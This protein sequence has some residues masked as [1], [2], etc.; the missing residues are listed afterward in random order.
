LQA[1]YLKLA[2]QAMNLSLLGL[3]DWGTEMRKAFGFVLTL[4][5][6]TLVCAQSG[7]IVEKTFTGVSTDTNPVSARK[8]ILDKGT[9]KISEDLIKELIGEDRFV[10][11]KTQIQNKVMRFSNRYVSVAKASEPQATSTGHTMTVNMKVSL[12]DLRALLQKNSLL[13]ENESAPLVLPVI[14]FND[15]IESRSFRWWKPEDT[16]KKSFLISQNRQF[17]NALRT[18]F[19]KNNFFLIK[20]MSMGPQVPRS[21]QNEHLSLDDMQLLS[22]YFGAPLILDG[23][24]Q[25][26]KSPDA[27]N[28]YRVEVKLLV[29]QVSN[30]RPIADVSRR[31]ETEAGAFEVETDRKLREVL[32]GTAQDLASQ[33]NEAWQK[34]ALGTT[35]LRLTFR[36]KI[37]FNQKE[38]FKEKL[39]TQ[40]RDIKNIRERFITAESVAY[41][42]DTSLNA[43]DFSTKMN[44][45]EIDGRRWTATS[46]N[47]S[48]VI[49]QTAR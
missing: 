4:L 10:K 45:L 31:F 48:E 26:T 46:Q 37:P 21:V 30:G 9:Q 24:V 15:K 47:D 42:V 43:K 12:K 34:G 8:E 33:L 32:D 29:M 6:A 38:A 27:N 25:Y 19:Q 41:E 49:L 5:F 39:R 40:V 14:A 36:G 16:T 23:Q 1:V 3:M 35:I 22:Q 28:R 17:E 13:S 44:G 7:E 11:N 2:R 20:S 18:A